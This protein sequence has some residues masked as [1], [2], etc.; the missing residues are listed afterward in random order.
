[1]IRERLSTTCGNDNYSVPAPVVNGLSISDLTGNRHP[2]SWPG[3]VDTGAGATVV[4]ISVCED[5]KLAPRD[6]QRPHGFDRQAPRRDIPRYYVKVGLEGIGQFTLLAYAVQRSNV[7]LG[8]DFLSGL[9]L[10]VDSDSS[11]W[12]LGR[13]S[14]WTKLILP[15]I[16]LR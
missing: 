3:L 8:R 5:L 1:M 15:L 4:P 13:A 7:L 16:A 12:Q 2:E 6:L 11:R 9:L 14:P 10:L